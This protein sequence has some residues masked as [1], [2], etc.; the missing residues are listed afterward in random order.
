MK[1]GFDE[2]GMAE[3]V[4]NTNEYALVK[5]T[6]M[7]KLLPSMQHELT[8][9]LTAETLRC[10]LAS[11]HSHP[12]VAELQMCRQLPPSLER[13]LCR[14]CTAGRQLCSKVGWRHP[15]AQMLYVMNC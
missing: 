13:S 12:Q 4:R 14:S 9:C 1:M 3:I 8:A 5:R 2:E 11:L 7:L 6:A 10:L 15:L